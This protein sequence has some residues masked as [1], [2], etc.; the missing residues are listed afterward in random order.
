MASGQQITIRLVERG[1]KLSNGFM[2]ARFRKLSESGYQTAFP[3]HRL[4]RTGC[5]AGAGHIWAM[6]PGEFL[7]SFNPDG[8]STIATIKFLRSAHHGILEI[9]DLPTDAQA[10]CRVTRHVRC[11]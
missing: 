8:L 4:R 11:H 9:C 5:G 10:Q 6:V 2:G 7:R 3:V 1:I